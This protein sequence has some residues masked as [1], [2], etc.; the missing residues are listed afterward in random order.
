[1]AKDLTRYY[2]ALAPFALLVGFDAI[3]SRPWCRP[4]L[5]LVVYLDY[6]YAWRAIPRNMAPRRVWEAL[7]E[8]LAR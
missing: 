6:V 2:V 5:A 1:M 4:V 7:Q 8:F 3:L